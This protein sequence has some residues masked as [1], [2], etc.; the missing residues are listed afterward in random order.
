MTIF[1]CI[2]KIIG[3]FSFHLKFSSTRMRDLIS[4]VYFSPDIN[5]MQQVQSV[6]NA[7]RRP[8]ASDCPECNFVLHDGSIYYSTRQSFPVSFILFL[9]TVIALLGYL[10]FI[11]FAGIGFVALPQQ[12]IQNY[13]WR[14]MPISDEE[15]VN[16]IILVVL[17]NTNIAI[18]RWRQ[19]KINLG[20]RAAA[21]ISKAKEYQKKKPW[22]SEFNKYK[23]VNDT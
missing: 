8:E 15:Y 4:K 9:I 16:I 22:R 14:P 2:L 23:K 18:F 19:R 5:T 1:Y 12:L 3:G 7:T 21:L 20:M 11:L 17:L 13:R 10:L 6:V